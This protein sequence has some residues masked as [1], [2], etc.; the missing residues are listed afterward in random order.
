MRNLKGSITKKEKKGI[1]TVI[2]ELKQQLHAK[3]SK[4]EEI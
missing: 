3:N 1:R 4:A 2:D